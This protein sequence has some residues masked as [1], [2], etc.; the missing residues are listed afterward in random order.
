MIKPLQRGGSRATPADSQAVAVRVA[1]IGLGLLVLVA[2]VFFR[3]WYLQV[4]SGNSF[5]ARAVQNRTRTIAIT[6]PRGGITHRNGT[7]LVRTRRQLIVSLNPMAVPD[8][9]D[10]ALAYGQ[11]LT[12][13]SNGVI[14]WQAAHPRTK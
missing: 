13:W 3:L 4:L 6:A 5:A 14:A 11:A 2:V 8:E 7:T 10:V 9:R 1:V 12:T